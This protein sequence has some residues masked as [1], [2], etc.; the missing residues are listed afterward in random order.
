MKYGGRLKKFNK[1]KVEQ[2]AHK[3]GWDERWEEFSNW[4]EKGIEYQNMLLN[5]VDED[6][7]AFNKIMD[8]F[9]LPKNSCNINC[10]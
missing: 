7:N 5:L 2:Q 10:V 3:R 6:T 4:A 9:R 1:E 8:A